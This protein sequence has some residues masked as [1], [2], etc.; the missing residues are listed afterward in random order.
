MKEDSIQRFFFEHEDVR[1]QVVHLH[2]AYQT[3]MTQ[4]AYPAHIRKI[5]G[6]SL[7][8]AV[9][10]ANT[11]KFKGDLTIQFQSKGPLKTIVAKC[12]HDN[13]IR[14]FVDWDHSASAEAISQNLGQG[15]LV[16]TIMQAG[17][18]PYQSIVP[19]ENH[20]VTEALEFY[21]A[22]TEQLS[23]RIWCAVTEDSA[24]GMM[25]QII[26]QS[27]GP[28]SPEKRELFWE[29]ATKLGE[30][31]TSEELLTLENQ[32]ILHRLFHEEDVRLFEAN[33]IAFQCSCDLDRMKN[34]IRM[35]GEADAMALLSTHK[36]ISIACEY[37]NAQ[38]AFNQAE[39]Q[40]IFHR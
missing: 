14:G 24:S 37:C 39:V 32:T 34:A 40:A 18:K 23:T 13:H 16:V 4:H 7:L 6:E 31:I 2:D 10:M 11:I 21:F 26:P 27:S 3:I 22:Q 19:L 20:T 5:L 8:A 9:M 33:A 38:Y 28:S 15:Q 29:H 1:G 35:L 25:L 17:Q 30:T 12:T 36:E